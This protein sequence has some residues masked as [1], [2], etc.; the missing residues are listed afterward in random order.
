MH[1]PSASLTSRTGSTPILS[2]LVL[3]GLGIAA[4]VLGTTA[5]AHAAK[6]FNRSFVLPSGPEVFNLIIETEDATTPVTVTSPL[7]TAPASCQPALSPACVGIGTN[8]G[9][10]QLESP[11][12]I[13]TGY[14][15]T[16]IT[17]KAH[18]GGLTYDILGLGSAGMSGVFNYPT[19]EDLSPPPPCSRSPPTPPATPIA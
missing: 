1:F 2:K 4:S 16:K 9:S 15:V 17:G 14:K 5:Q 19:E 12:Y 13:F 7:F 10:P 18:E 11:A 3:G 8:V 6:T